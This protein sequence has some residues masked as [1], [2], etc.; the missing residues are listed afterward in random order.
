MLEDGTAVEAD[1]GYSGDSEFDR[2]YIALFA[3]RVV[4]GCAMNGTNRATGKDLGVETGG[5]LG[6]LVIP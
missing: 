5:N 2:Q 4:T 3:G 6:V 1:A